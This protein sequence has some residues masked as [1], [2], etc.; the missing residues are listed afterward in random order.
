MFA[1]E[2][3]PQKQHWLRQS[4][5][6]AIFFGFWFHMGLQ[7][8]HSGQGVTPTQFGDPHHLWKQHDRHT[9]DVLQQ[10][11][12]SLLIQSVHSPVSYH[13][14]RHALSFWVS[15]TAFCSSSLAGKFEVLIFKFKCYFR[16][17]LLCPI[18]P[19]AQPSH[20]S[21]IAFST[22]LLDYS[23]LFYPRVSMVLPILEVAENQWEIS[24]QLC[25]WTQLY[26]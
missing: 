6:R 2:W 9:R 20:T 1:G 15:Q 16:P 23:H 25:M 11:S 13:N 21:Q 3:Q 22:T 12:M 24:P 8:T 18:L 19:S 26:Q 7:L 17:F 5:T 14:V 4:P 10:F